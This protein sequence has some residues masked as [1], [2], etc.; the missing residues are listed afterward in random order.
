M[1]N[2]ITMSGSFLKQGFSTVADAFF[3]GGRAAASITTRGVGSFFPAEQREKVVPSIVSN[4]PYTTFVGYR[5]I[6][7]EV[8]T[9]RSPFANWWQTKIVQPVATW[10]QGQKIKDISKSFS[11]TLV[12]AADA[13]I[14]KLGASLTDYYINKWGLQVRPVE[15][16]DPYGYYNTNVSKAPAVTDMVKDFF[17]MYPSQP[18]G[19]YFIANPQSSPMPATPIDPRS[20]YPGGAGTVIIPAA[21]STGGGLNIMPFLIIG[22][23]VGV[24][25]FLRK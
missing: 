11:N 7:P 13:G 4:Q 6:T 3:P 24:V 2:F 20:D 9:L 1:N 18:A 23:I 12:T 15:P 10:Y 17:T 22:G 21:G 8:Q 5:P 16:K 14:K 25:Y 19:S